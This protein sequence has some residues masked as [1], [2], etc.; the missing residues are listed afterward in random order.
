MLKTKARRGSQESARRK[1]ERMGSAFMSVCSAIVSFLFLATLF[2][3]VFR[4]PLL[5]LTLAF[6]IV[7]GVAGGACYQLLKARRL[8]QSQ[9]WPR[10]RHG[11]G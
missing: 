3:F 8:K 4:S 10:R 6:F 1:G 2:V 11:D 5:V 7:V 9:V